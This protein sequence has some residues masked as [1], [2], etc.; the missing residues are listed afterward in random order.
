M[1]ACRDVF[2]FIETKLAEKTYPADFPFF[3]AI[4]RK[5]DFL[6]GGRTEFSYFLHPIYH[7]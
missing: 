6:L 1:G 3:A 4:A 5:T 2:V 7:Q